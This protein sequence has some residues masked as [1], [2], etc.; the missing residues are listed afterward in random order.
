MSA[1]Q[2]SS[3]ASVSS[4]ACVSVGVD[5]LLHRLSQMIV[6]ERDDNATI[7]A[8][9]TVTAHTFAFVVVVVIV[10]MTGTSGIVPMRHDT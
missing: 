5:D 1:L 8:F 4:G 7:T 9:I 3:E 2:F 6:V 10:L